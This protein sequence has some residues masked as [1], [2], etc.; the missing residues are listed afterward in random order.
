MKT[1]KFLMQPGSNHEVTC[2]INDFT[3]EL[4]KFHHQPANLSSQFKSQVWFVRVE[5]VP[6]A[7]SVITG[8]FGNKDRQMQFKS[9]TASQV[10]ALVE[11]GAT[12]K[13]NTGGL[14]FYESIIDGGWN[15]DIDPEINSVHTQVKDT[16]L[17]ETVMTTGLPGNHDTT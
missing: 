2:K 17:T 5:G 6:G 4:T 9:T 11:Y 8:T 1:T 16:A 13:Y 10:D 14:D 7:A 12:I 3:L 15:T